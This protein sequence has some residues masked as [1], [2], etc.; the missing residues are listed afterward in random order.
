MTKTAFAA[1]AVSAGVLLSA[2]AA[3]AA[4]PYVDPALDWSG[5]YAGLYAGYG[6]GDSDANGDDG[7]FDEAGP[8]TFS[9][10]TD[11]FLGGLTLGH[12][13]QTS[14]LVFGLEAELG[15]NGVE[16]SKFIV[17]SPDNFGEIDYGLYGTLAARFGVASNNW[18]LYGKLG[19]VLSELDHRAGDLAGTTPDAT[20]LARVNKAAWGGLVGLGAEYAFSQTWSA[21][22][23]YNFMVFEDFGRTNGDGDRFE[24]ENNVH[25]VKLGINMHF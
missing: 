19:G 22:L 17:P 11:G 6:F 10:N 12:N 20:D 24:F 21:K 9:Q 4:D 2:T 5:Y 25:V 15:Y 8:E 7:A 23:E 3:Q 1:L 18:L 13:W 14:S 16:D